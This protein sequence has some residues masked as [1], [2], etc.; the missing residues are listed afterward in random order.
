MTRHNRD[1]EHQDPDRDIQRQADYD[2]DRSRNT[3]EDIDRREHGR[4]ES[5]GESDRGEY[6]REGGRG[7]SSYG[8]ER[9]GFDDEPRRPPFERRE[10]SWGQPIWLEGRRAGQ[11]SGYGRDSGARGE[12]AWGEGS[13]RE[14]YDASR[15]FPG[16]RGVGH[17]VEPYGYGTARGAYGQRGQD[18][19]AGQGPYDARGE[20][21]FEP[22]PSPWRERFG[23][24]E[25]GDPRF[26]IGRGYG[27]TGGGRVWDQWAEGEGE[28]FAGRGPK[29]YQRSD[30]RICEDI[31]ERLT[32]HPQI[33][34]SECEVKVQGGEVTLIGTVNSRRAKRIA[35]DLAE[36]VSGV[37]DVSNQLRVKGSGS[38]GTADRGLPGASGQS[39]GPP[40]SGGRSRGA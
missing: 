12:F 26:E 23:N 18:R 30:E 33:D 10:Q 27:P 16:T 7:R 32:E 31:S 37:K 2:Y 14:A 21:Q 5:R 28:S 34:A 17:E 29:G 9:G 39:S 24:R 6:G 22:A 19:R 1:R 36:Q 35:E 25:S 13:E 20:G 15:G 4:G 8:V 3:R 40:A 38:Q 11:G